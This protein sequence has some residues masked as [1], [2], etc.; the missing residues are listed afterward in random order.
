MP[1]RSYDSNSYCSRACR[2]SKQASKQAFLFVVAV[3]V[4]A[5]TIVDVV[6]GAGEAV[7]ATTVVEAE[8]VAMGNVVVEAIDAASGPAASARSRRPVPR[9][10]ACVPLVPIDKQPSRHYRRSSSLSPK[11]SSK[12]V[13]LACV[14]PLIV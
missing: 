13:C 1:S 3:E 14:R 12:A 7:T 10:R 2:A 6:E 9:R 11:K 8:V 5:T 4:V